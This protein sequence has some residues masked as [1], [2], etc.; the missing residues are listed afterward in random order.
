[1]KNVNAMLEVLFEG[2]QLKRWNGVYKAEDFVETSKQGLNA[3]IAYVLA[4]MYEEKEEYKVNYSTLIELSICRM[5]YKTIFTDIN[6]S[7]SYRLLN[8]LKSEANAFAVKKVKELGFD[9]DF[10]EMFKKYLECKDSKASVELQIFH[11]ASKLATY[12][13]F[14]QIKSGAGQNYLIVKMEKNVLERL[15]AIKSLEVVKDFMLSEKLNSF[16]DLYANTAFIQRWARYEM[17]PKVSDLSHMYMT[18]VV[19]YLLMMKGDFSE[20]RCAEGFYAGLF[21]DTIEL[22]TGDLPY[23][24]KKNI[25]G[26]KSRLTEIELEEYKNS[27]KPLLPEYLN[28]SIERYI[29][30]TIIDKSKKMVKVADNISAYVEVITSVLTGT[31]QDYFINVIERDW[32]QYKSFEFEDIPVK[33]VY[34]HFYEK[35]LEHITN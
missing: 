8:G 29:L 12:W 3:A 24:L 21:H 2:I 10:C 4:K 33:E 14:N 15:E 32:E 18:A 9:D 19:T 7:I 5:V 28:K 17:S 6:P 11:A 25:P 34:K 22:L 16:I 23:P 30:M 31:T 13:E 27:I 35:Y 1:M 20:K 26:L